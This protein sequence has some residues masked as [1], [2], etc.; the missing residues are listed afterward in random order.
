MDASKLIAPGA[1]VVVGVSGGADSVALLAALRTLSDE[2]ERAY[3]LTAAHLNH[4]LRAEADA[5]AA[6]VSDLAGRWCLPCISQRRDVRGAARHRG[7]GIEEAGRDLRYGFFAE[8]A[9]RVGAACVAVG[10]HADDQV[11]TV[12]HRIIRGTHLRGLCGM[13][14]Q[15][16]LGPGGVR[17]VRPLLTCRRR[18]I[19]AFLTRLGLPW[20]TDHT[21]ADTAYRRNLIRHELLPLLREKLHPRADEAILRLAEAAGEAQTVIED[22]GDQALVEAA[23]ARDEHSMALSIAAMTPRPR[24]VQ[25][26]C[27]RMVLERVGV[28]LRDVGAETMARLCGLISSDRPTALSLPGGF[29]AC[30]RSGRLVIAET[31]PRIAAPPQPCGKE[32]PL[33]CPGQSVL[34]DGREICCETMPFDLAEFESHC[35]THR[36]GVEMID[37]DRVVGSLRCRPRRQGDAFVP[38]GAPGR[39]SVSDF[40]TNRKLPPEARGRVCCLCDETGIVYVAPF[41]IAD[42]V[43]LSERSRRV[44][45]LTVSGR[46]GD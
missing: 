34:W 18:D 45:R 7:Q 4:G 29:H 42:R 6:W 44:L 14:A 13:P 41:Q 23:E 19:E 3:R 32:I 37:A 15:R 9:H 43:R 16:P 27:L 24:V 20:R 38:L 2:P 28:P 5:D 46:P 12:L 25:A 36:P 22:L 40:L 21:N 1:G 11:E 31:A 17:L 35:R 8:T 30:V 26:A 33:A 39:Q 10:H